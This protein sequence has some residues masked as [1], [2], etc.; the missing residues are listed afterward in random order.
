MITDFLFLLAIY[1][2]Y[3]MSRLWSMTYNY[4]PGYSITF[5][6]VRTNSPELS[7][8]THNTDYN[9]LNRPQSIPT[10]VIKGTKVIVKR[11]KKGII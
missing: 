9:V 3:L 4:A 7:A 5:G 6:T 11:L 1:F 10:V 2:C 8:M